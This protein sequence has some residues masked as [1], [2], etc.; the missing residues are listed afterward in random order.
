MSRVKGFISKLFGK[1]EIQNRMAKNAVK[2]IVGDIVCLYEEFRKA[3]GPGAL[4]FSAAA[5]DNS[6][7]MKTKEIY[8]DIILAEEQCDKG[9]KD[10]LQT[11]LN[12]IEKHENDKAAIVVLVERTGLSLMVIDLEGADEAIEKAAESCK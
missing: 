5:P 10:F 12:V 4:F 11:T 7:Y 2:M 8:N 3:E 6:H 9:T 1:S